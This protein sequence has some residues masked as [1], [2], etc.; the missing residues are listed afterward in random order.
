MTK[1]ADPISKLGCSHMIIATVT[2]DVQDIFEG[3]LPRFLH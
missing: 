1:Y 2:T 3:N